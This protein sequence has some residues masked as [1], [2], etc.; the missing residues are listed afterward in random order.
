MKVNR[1]DAS[2]ELYI[3][4]ELCSRQASMQEA[5]QSSW[6]WF[7]GYLRM[8]VHYCPIHSRSPER[9]SAFEKSRTKP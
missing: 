5:A 9:N 6:D 7:T 4:C 8:T 2:G 3:Q 1:T